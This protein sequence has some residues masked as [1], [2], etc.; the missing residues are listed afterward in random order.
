MSGEI[1]E[2][3]RPAAPLPRRGPAPIER[4][5]PGVARERPARAA[6]SQSGGARCDPRGPPATARRPWRQPPDVGGEPLLGGHTGMVETL[7][8]CVQSQ[9]PKR[10]ASAASS[11]AAA[12]RPVPARRPGPSDLGARG[13]AR[14]P[15]AP[16][17]PQA[18]VSRRGSWAIG[19]GLPRVASPRWPAVSSHSGHVERAPASARPPVAGPDDHRR[20]AMLTWP[21]SSSPCSPRRSPCST[22]C[23]P[24][25]H[26]ATRATVAGPDARS[27]V[28]LHRRP[29]GVRDA[30]PAHRPVPAGDA[31]RR[32]RL[33]PP[34][35]GGHARAGVALA[36]TARSADRARPLPC[37]W[38]PRA[39]PGA[40]LGP[41]ARDVV[42][43]SEKAWWSD[44]LPGRFRPRA[45]VSSSATR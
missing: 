29:G 35:D 1:S 26:R 20:R 13:R 4:W 3:P 44:F 24:R 30:A 39:W 33:R 22:G 11:T 27:R 31:R 34:D 25:R 23:R 6:R 15:R 10:T 43:P 37:G 32:S 7:G 21:G 36:R 19:S 14:R 42:A 38:P 40:R 9:S 41:E 8:Q 2:C 45:N 28:R 18:A 5:S 17:R 12:R 16:G